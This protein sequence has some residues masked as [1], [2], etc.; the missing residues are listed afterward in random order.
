MKI[1]IVGNSPILLE[2]ELGKEIDSHDMVIRFN[3]FKIDGYEKHCGSKTTDICFN[4]YTPCN[5][6]VLNLPK[7][8]RLFFYTT[9]S[10]ESIDAALKETYNNK[11]SLNDVTL[12]DNEKY[13]KGVRDKLKAENN[14]QGSSGLIMCQMMCDLYPEATIDVYG[15]TFFKD[16]IRRKEGEAYHKIHHMDGTVQL[17][18]HDPDAEWNYYEK[19]LK[20]KINLHL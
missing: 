1:A 18:G 6:Y 5:S 3:N 15:I 9:Q 20:D 2:K 16:T 7:E 4:Q 17:S 11:I 19:Y 14:W 12:I 8:H 13:Y 10:L